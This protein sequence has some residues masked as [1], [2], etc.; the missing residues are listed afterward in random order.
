MACGLPVIGTD[1]P[2]IR[3]IISNEVNG[4]LCEQTAESLAGAIHRVI[5]DVNLRERLGRNARELVE[6]EFG[7]TVVVRKEEALIRRLLAGA[8]DAC[9]G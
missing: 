2:G 5:S 9:S 8:S 6:R 1:V 7:Q 4:I 3:E